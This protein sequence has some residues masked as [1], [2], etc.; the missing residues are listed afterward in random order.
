ME[1]HYNYL[2][3][4]L[5]NEMK[6]AGKRTCQCKTEDDPY[7]GSGTF[8]KK[9]IKMYGENNFKKIILSESKTKEENEA[10]EIKLIDMLD[11]VNSK[12]YYNIAHG[13]PSRPKGFVMDDDEKRKV[14]YLKEMM[15]NEVLYAVKIEDT[16]GRQKDTRRIMFM[17]IPASGKEY[18]MYIVS[19]DTKNINS[20]N[21]F[22]GVNKKT[23]Y[24]KYSDDIAP[25]L[26]GT[27][28]MLISK[29]KFNEYFVRAMDGTSSFNAVSCEIEMEHDKYFQKIKNLENRHITESDNAISKETNDVKM[30]N[31]KKVDVIG[32]NANNSIKDCVNM[33]DYIKVFAKESNDYRNLL[34]LSNDYNDIGF[35][36]VI[37]AI[38]RM[39]SVD[40]NY[41]KSGNF[42][43]SDEQAKLASSILDYERKFAG[44]K[45][46]GRRNYFNI[47]IAFCY[48]IDRV[49]NDV[50]LR[51]IKN[52]S[53]EIP[54]V[55][56]IEQILGKIDEIYNYRL[57]NDKKVSI[58]NLYLEIKKIK[59]N[60]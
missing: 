50:L 30:T 51:K 31:V 43:C 44:I 37:N 14:E 18:F 23:K 59:N 57:P 25:W 5:I 41:I 55:K 58:L 24:R 47:A 13:G 1:N 19:N 39:G 15:K 54:K 42:K 33:M 7:L 12:E 20:N 36:E 17:K 52:K 34:N 28:Y 8:L 10:N 40:A 46:S 4:N 27:N 22:G 38:T 35:I 3:I 6:Y 21:F 60:N 29:D 49:D 9:A 48:L 2:V 32:V 53:S 45:I 56:K 11:A 16:K 26:H